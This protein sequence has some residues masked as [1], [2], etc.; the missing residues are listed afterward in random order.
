MLGGRDIHLIEIGQKEYREAFDLYVSRDDNGFSLVDCHI[1]TSVRKFGI[2]GVVSF[3]GDFDDEG[4]AV[5]R[6]NIDALPF[7]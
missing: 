6:T 2:S 5:I 7:S 1:M 4:I 3:D